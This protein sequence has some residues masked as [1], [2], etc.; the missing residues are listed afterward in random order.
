MN[1]FLAL[2]IFLLIP[3]DIIG[4]AYALYCAFNIYGAV[5]FIMT[6]II[7]FVQILLT[8]AF[9]DIINNH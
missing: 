1:K 5:L 9:I 2:F 3:V 7:I 6:F 4:I 8:C